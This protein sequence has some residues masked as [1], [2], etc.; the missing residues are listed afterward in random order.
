[1]QIDVV[2]YK[3]LLA[4]EKKRHFDRGLYLYC[5]ESGHKVDN[6]PKKQHR[7]TFKMKNATT[8]SNSEPKNG[9]AQHNRDH[10]VGLFTSNQSRSYPL[11]P[12]FS[13]L[14]HPISSWFSEIQDTCSIR[15]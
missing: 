2:R 7:H 4:Q 5:R 15:F 8:S 12:V 1:M 13:L 6:C 11:C 3:Q 14:Y 10:A 9:E